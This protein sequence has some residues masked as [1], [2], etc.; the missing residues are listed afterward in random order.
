MKDKDNDS[1]SEEEEEEETHTGDMDQD[2]VE[3][4]YVNPLGAIDADLFKS[5]SALQKWNAL[6]L[7]EGERCPCLEKDSQMR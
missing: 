4:G 5:S 2:L 6:P 7:K 3:D 1:H